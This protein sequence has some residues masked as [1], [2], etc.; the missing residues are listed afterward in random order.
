MQPILVSCTVLEQFAK[1]NTVQVN[2]AA[3]SSFISLSPKVAIEGGGGRGRVLR[4]RQTYNDSVKDCIETGSAFSDR[5][6]RVRPLR[7]C[8]GNCKL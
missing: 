2:K 6:E 3:S 5:G 1:K 8:L 4:G 7:S